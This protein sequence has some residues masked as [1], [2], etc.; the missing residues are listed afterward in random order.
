V[1]VTRY[2]PENL[3]EALAEGIVSGH[4]DMPEFVFEPAEIEAILAYLGALTPE[5]EP[6]PESEPAPEPEAEP[7]ATPDAEP[8]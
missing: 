5:A 3:A 8:Q 4:P 1:V 7:E 2:P 6:G